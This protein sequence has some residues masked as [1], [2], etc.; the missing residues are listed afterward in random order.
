LRRG[1][2]KEDTAAER[3]RI[4]GSIEAGVER[5]PNADD[6]AD[7]GLQ[8]ECAGDRERPRGRRGASS[9]K[10]TIVHVGVGRHNGASIG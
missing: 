5:I 10:R 9:R 4:E 8:D 6:R 2:L 7:P 1:L 3:C